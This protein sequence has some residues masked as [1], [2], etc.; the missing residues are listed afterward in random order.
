MEEA[1]ARMWAEAL[2]IDRVGVTDDFF[3]LGG[4][5]L[6]AVRLFRRIETVFKRKLPLATL[7]DSPTVEKLSEAL[8]GSGGGDV[9][10][11]MIEIERGDGRLPLF[12]VAT[13]DA[14]IYAALSVALG[15]DQPVYGLHPQGIVP[16]ESPQ[17][18]I[19]MIASR[20]IDEIQKVRPHGPYVLGG[21]CAGGVVAYEIARQ[22]RAQ[23]E[24][25]P[26]VALID[27]PGPFSPAFKL[28]LRL[29]RANRFG[30][31]MYHHILNLWKLDPKGKVEYFLTRLKRLAAKLAGR[32]VPPSNPTTIRNVERVYWMA[33]NG[34]YMRSMERY[35]P[36][37]FDGRLVLFVAKESEAWGFS[38]GRV[39]WMKFAGGGADTHVIPGMHADILHEGPAGLIAKHLE[40]YLAEISSSQAPQ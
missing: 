19:K 38:P 8:F 12:C 37:R 23:G 29:R 25:V 33:F 14:F 30:D 5:S 31:H 20:Y 11:P 6:L 27:T 24:E 2:G 28:L 21:M 1:L 36:H 3:A 22:L 34:A 32:K 13:A 18:D 39:K 26:L 40:K 17:I 16:H 10:P 35:R 15:A 4:H 7:F 9:F